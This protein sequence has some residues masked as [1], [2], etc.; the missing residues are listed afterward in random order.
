MWAPGGVGWC[1]DLFGW[2]QA[3]INVN[4]ITK[5]LEEHR[6]LKSEEDKATV[7]RYLHRQRLDQCA[8]LGVHGRHHGLLCRRGSASQKLCELGCVDTAD[9]SMGGVED[10]LVLGLTVRIWSS[11]TP[12]THRLHGRR[13]GPLRHRD[14][15]GRRVVDVGGKDA[16]TVLRWRLCTTL[17]WAT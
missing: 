4:G 16:R 13:N 9:D 8:L 6:R 1:G 5:Q 2:F 17:R 10:G 7:G 15:K 12:Q 3:K 14:N 11:G